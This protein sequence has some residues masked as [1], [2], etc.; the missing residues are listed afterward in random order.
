MAQSRRRLFAGVAVGVIAL[1][2]GRWT[3]EFATERLWEARVSES[4]A[5]VGT[6]FAIIRGALELLGL[7]A[8]IGWFTGHLLWVIQSLLLQTGEVPKSLVRLSERSLYFAAAGFG[9]IFGVA[10]GG[11]TGSWL[12]ATLLA[13]TNLTFG[14]AD[15]LL[16]VDLGVFAADLP[17]W[18]LL[19]DRAWAMVLPAL[20]MV[21]FLNTFGGTLRFADRRFWLAPQSRPQFGVLLACVAGL[22][23]WLAAA[24]ALLPGYA[25][26]KSA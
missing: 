7:V 12:H 25:L 15:P 23:G 22:I 16:Q 17:L 4:A 20:V 14:V 8:A 6:R 19:Y 18:E 26:V 13:G 1:I 11:G 3:A 2:L 5:L 10:V 9:L 21:A 24:I